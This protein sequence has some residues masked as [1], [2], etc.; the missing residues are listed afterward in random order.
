M[1]N[2]YITGI[3][4]MLGSNMA[5]ILRTRYN[6]FGID[7]NV[8]E[9]KGV[10]NYINKLDDI[11]LLKEQLIKHNI[12]VLIHCAALVNVDFCEENPQL[13]YEMN[14]VLTE[15]L[16][17]VC[18]E[19]GIKMIFISSDAVF[20]GKKLDLYS[21]NDI[22][23]PVSV[24]GKTKILAEKT[25]LKHPKNLV[26]RTNIYGFNYRKKTSFGE[27]IV[28]SLQKG[29]E[30]NMADD[31]LFSPIIVNEFVNIIYMCIENDLYGIYH[32]C[33]TGA[34]S[35]YEIALIFKKIFDSTTVVNRV[36]LENINFKAPRTKNMGLDNM[37]IREK[38]KIHISTPADSVRIF[39]ELYN[40]KYRDLLRN[41]KA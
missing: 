40:K 28:S 24:Y 38:L 20:D 15:K 16:S 11:K 32:V 18:N 2:V 26:I 10:V 33:G 7:R 22:A 17:D 5:Y 12:D 14:T 31:I 1:K 30:L 36:S 3:A 29:I 41:G 25:V 35:K 8:I 37:A 39:H 13:A 4:G 21:E 9:I 19:L 23:L 6:I 34:I 27:W